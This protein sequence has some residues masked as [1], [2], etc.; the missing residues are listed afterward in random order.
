[1]G[2]KVTGNRTTEQRQRVADAL[3]EAMEKARDNDV[4]PVSFSD[5]LLAVSAKLCRMS[6]VDEEAYVNAAREHYREKNI[7]PDSDD[8]TELK[9]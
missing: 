5:L 2:L 7:D 6:G 8:D 1:M 3:H 4:G 9:H